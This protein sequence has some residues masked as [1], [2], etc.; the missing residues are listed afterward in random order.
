MKRCRFIG[1]RWNSLRSPAR[2]VYRVKMNRRHGP[3]LPS[4]LNDLARLAMRQKRAA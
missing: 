3:L 2:P 4:E 1:F